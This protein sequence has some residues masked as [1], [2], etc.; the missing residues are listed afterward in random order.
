M[1]AVAG[2]AQTA[3][4]AVNVHSNVAAEL[5]RV[6]QPTVPRPAVGHKPGN[7]QAIL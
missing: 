3:A 7:L 1:T 5:P 2:A 4:L 6:L